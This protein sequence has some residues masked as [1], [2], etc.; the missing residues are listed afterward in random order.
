[1]TFSLLYSTIIVMSI[2]LLK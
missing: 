2:S 1:M